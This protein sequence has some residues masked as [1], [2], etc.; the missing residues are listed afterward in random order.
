M[1]LGS[2]NR[3]PGSGKNLPVLRIP[4]PGVKKALDP[5]SGSATL[6]SNQLTRHFFKTKLKFPVK[7]SDIVYFFPGKKL[8]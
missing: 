3:D 4:D 6:P 7:N 8:Y 2:G 1:G 5:G